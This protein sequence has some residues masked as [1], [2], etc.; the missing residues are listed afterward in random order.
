MMGNVTVTL[1]VKDAAGVNSDPITVTP[2][3]PSLFGPPPTT[4]SIRPGIEFAAGTWP[5]TK[6]AADAPLDPN[7]AAIVKIFTDALPTHQ[8]AVYTM[9]LLP[10]YIVNNGTPTSAV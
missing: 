2:T 3:W 10:L 9:G 6:L 1:V 8:A 7:S 4:L 5:H